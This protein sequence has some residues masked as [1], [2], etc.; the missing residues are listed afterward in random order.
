[1]LIV[2]VSFMRRRT[3]MALIIYDDHI[4]IQIPNSEACVNAQHIGIKNR[5]VG[6]YYMS[7]SPDAVR[8]FL[9]DLKGTFYIDFCKTVHNMKR[10]FEY[11]QDT[12]S[13]DLFKSNLM[14]QFM[15]QKEITDKGYDK[16]YVKIEDP[17]INAQAKYLKFTRTN[18][19]VRLF[20]TLLL[21][22]LSDLIIYKL[23]DNCFMLYGQADPDYE[24]KIDAKFH[25]E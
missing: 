2:M 16:T 22:D 4:K 6:S 18:S 3:K 24:Y 1:M 21:G 14:D 10:V 13:M 19:D 17:I 20:Q 7:E 11:I 5:S 12:D 25:M 23:D 15:A 9:N 8:S